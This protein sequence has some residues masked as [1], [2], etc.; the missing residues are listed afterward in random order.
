MVSHQRSFMRKGLPIYSQPGFVIDR[1]ISVYYT[2]LFVVVG[3][4]CRRSDFWN[5]F[6]GRGYQRV[7]RFA[8]ARM[9]TFANNN[10]C[11]LGC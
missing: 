4:G 9:E 6:H 3:D 11:K 5:S 7:W 10:V 1:R 8:Q 2:Q